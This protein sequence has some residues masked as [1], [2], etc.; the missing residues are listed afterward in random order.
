VALRRMEAVDQS[1][2]VILPL[3]DEFGGHLDPNVIR[4][5]ATHELSLFDGAKVRDFVPIIAWRL[6][7][8]RLLDEVSRPGPAGVHRFDD[9]HR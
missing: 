5:V 9:P 7:R 3:I 4:E 1:E 6:A 8:A 2:L